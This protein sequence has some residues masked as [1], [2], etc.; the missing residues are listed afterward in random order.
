MTKK[1]LL[2]AA[3]LSVGV[4]GLASG[5]YATNRAPIVPEVSAAEAAESG[6]PYVVK[7][8]AQWC[9]VCML[10]KAMWSQVETMYSTR[11]NLVV[12][13]FTNQASTD[14]SRAEARRLGLEG[15]FNENA[16]WTGTIAVL[17]GRT[18]DVTATIHGSRDFSEYRAAIDAAL[19][20]ATR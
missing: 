4:V 11:V 10:T 13:D 1:A 9:P 3:S 5:M 19:K 7:L 18:K 15:F 16:G 2:I 20:G 17:N 12:F 8:H 14:A 6:K